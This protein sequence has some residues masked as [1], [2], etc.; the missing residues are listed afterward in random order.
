MV[1]LTVL[2]HLCFITKNIFFSVEC[3]SEDG[4]ERPKRVGDLRHFFIIAS[5]FSAVFYR[6]TVHFDIYTVHTP[7]NSILL[8][9]TKF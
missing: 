6:C 1:N 4:R 5:N 7:T 2:L 8:N 9:F 3:L